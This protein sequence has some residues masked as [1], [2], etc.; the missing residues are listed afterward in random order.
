M[1]EG[2]KPLPKPRNGYHRMHSFHST[3]SGKSSVGFDRASAFQSC[4]YYLFSLP[5]PFRDVI[6]LR[7]NKIQGSYFNSLLPSAQKEPFLF[8]S[9]LYLFKSQS[10]LHVNTYMY[11]SKYSILSFPVYPWLLSSFTKLDYIEFLF[12]TRVVIHYVSTQVYFDTRFKIK[13]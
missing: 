6:K 13:L 8:I 4:Y 9:W 1:S 2:G 12:I 7:A 11:T 3:L 10:D 5:W